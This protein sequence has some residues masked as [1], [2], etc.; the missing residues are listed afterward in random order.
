VR[1]L[2]TGGA[3]FIGSHLTDALVARGDEVL[4][5]DDLSTGKRER[6][7]AALA[8]G[9]ELAVEDITDGAAMLRVAGEF[10]PEA[11]FHLAAQMDV[12][13]SVADPGHD[14]RV[15]VVGTV[16]VLEAAHRAHAESD[17]SAAIV[18]TSSGGV[19]YGE[20][21]GK[22]LP[23]TE[24]SELSPESP[25]GQ[26]K[27]AGE[28]YVDYHRR[29]HG[30]RAVSLR[31]GN[32]YGPRQDPHGEAGVVAIF[33][34]RL[35]NGETPKIFGDGRQT[36]DYVYVEDTVE[37]LLAAQRALDSANRPIAP[38]YNVGTGRETSVLELL[39]VMA[40]L[41]GREGIEPEMAPARAGEL[42]RN[43]VDASLAA[44]DL[45]WTPKMELEPG[46][47]L[48]VETL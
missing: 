38:A 11:V 9:A 34:G 12:R 29:V 16:N 6:L 28:G 20:G 45:G 47:A 21:A 18:F 13:R 15:N 27:L 40:R 33:G 2:V 22:P 10:K 7:E 46:L 3:G 35:R 8:A 43:V 41:M 23:H 48:T 4:V 32:I 30:A 36:R 1:C 25:Y 5:V 14:A 42:Q 31:L 26:S 17:R 44:G 24:S 37:A 39:E 19:V